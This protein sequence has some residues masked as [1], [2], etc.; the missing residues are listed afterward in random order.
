MVFIVLYYTR[1]SLVV[2]VTYFDTRWLAGIQTLITLR[3]K[4]CLM[5]EIASPLSL[6]LQHNNFLSPSNYILIYLLVSL[7]IESTCCINLKVMVPGSKY[8]IIL[9]NFPITNPHPF[10]L[11]TYTSLFY[12]PCPLFIQPSWVYLNCPLT[13]PI[14]FPLL[15]LSPSASFFLMFCSP[16]PLLPS[17]AP[18]TVVKFHLPLSLCV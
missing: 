2:P 3:H 17:P 8:L 4:A 15:S 11:S 16:L 14:I 1:T 10:P 9:V 7:Y 12:S 5:D 6:L 13:P 18:L